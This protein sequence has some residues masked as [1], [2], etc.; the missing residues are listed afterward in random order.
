MNKDDLRAVLQPYCHSATMA[1]QGLD[2][3]LE[4]IADALSRGD[5]VRLHGI[6]KLKPV[7]RAGRHGKGGITGV[8]WQTADSNS[9][10]L[11]VADPL[12][13]RLNPL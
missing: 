1:A 5:A 8:A 6:G 12:K 11:I 2:A 4:A 9:V 13:A 7:R 10:R 3:L